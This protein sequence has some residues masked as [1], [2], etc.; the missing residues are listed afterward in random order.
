MKIANLLALHREKPDVT[1]IRTW[2]AD[3]NTPMIAINQRIGF[4]VT[5]RSTERTKDL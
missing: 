3:T 5:D 4:S 2:N 1:S